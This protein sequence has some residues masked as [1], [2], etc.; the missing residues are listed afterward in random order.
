MTM[1]LHDYLQDVQRLLREQK[2]V[3]AN[4]TDLTR[5]I[6]RARREVAMRSQAI[7][8]LTP[9][10]A[11]IVSCKVDTKG[12]GYS[13][14][15]TVTVSTPDFPGGTWNDPNG[16][17]A[18][19]QATV[20]AGQ[21][22]G[23]DILDGGSGYFQPTVTITDSTGTGAT[24][25][26]VVGPISTVNQGQEQYRYSDIDLSSVPGAASVY[27]VR[28]AS[29]IY[30]SFRYSLPCYGFSSYQA[31]IRTYPRQYQYVPVM[32]SQFGQ[33]ASGSLFFFPLPSQT[34]QLELDCQLIP[35]DLVTNQSV[36]L[37]PEPWTDAVL[38]FAAH[39]FYLEAQNLNGARGCLELYDRFAQRYSD[40]SRAG[41]VI[42]PY[43]RT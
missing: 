6:N 39:F 9:I 20:E 27:F 22:V 3:L 41:R 10:S 26:L 25:E 7:R 24:A 4:P 36:E 5:Y 38:Y 23:I 40:Y 35:A 18:T 1:T 29:I 16:R 12:S 37:L 19:A 17:Q 34:Y 30:S 14:T 43:G 33:G 28:S 11:P 42:N 2:Q 13:P 32:F 21:V 15:P 8:F 31:K